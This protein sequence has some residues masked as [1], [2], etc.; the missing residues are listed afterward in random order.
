ML[1]Y[2]PDPLS[3]EEKAEALGG[4]DEKEL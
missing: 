4:Y 3:E 2:N 1:F